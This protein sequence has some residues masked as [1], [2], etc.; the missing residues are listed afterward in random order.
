LYYKGRQKQTTQDTEAAKT[1]WQ[2]Y[3]ADYNLYKPPYEG[4]VQSEEE[5]K[6]RQAFQRIVPPEALQG[7]SVDEI[8]AAQ[9][10]LKA[11]GQTHPLVAI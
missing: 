1:A 4:P 7:K 5:G 11:Y 9:G 10:Q 6:A 8:V 3:V 2:Q